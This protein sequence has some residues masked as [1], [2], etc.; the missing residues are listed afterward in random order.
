MLVALVAENR[1][2]LGL[3]WV[4]PGKSKLVDVQRL[5]GNRYAP[6]GFIHREGDFGHSR[7]YYFHVGSFIVAS[8]EIDFFPSHADEPSEKWISDTDTSWVWV[9]A[10]DTKNELQY[11]ADHTPTPP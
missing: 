4:T 8:Y 11:F 7:I 10:H 9:M 2:L 5:L 6:E 1:F 3:P